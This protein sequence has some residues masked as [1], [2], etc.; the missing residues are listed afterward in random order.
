[1]HSFWD[2][3]LW[4]NSI[5]AWAT[6]VGMIIVSLLVLRMFKTIVLQRVKKLTQK[7]KGGFDDFLVSVVE[8]AVMPWLYCLAIY[9]SIQYLKIDARADKF[10]QV[11]IMVISTF[12]IV[13][14]ITIFLSYIVNRFIENSD[15]PESKR[16]QA[17]GILM[18]VK[19]VVYAI[20]LVFLIDN[21]GYDITTIVTGLG[22][23]GIAIAL[24]AQTILGDLFSYLVIF[25]DKPFEIGDYISMGTDS[26]TVEHIGIKTT[27]LKTLSGEQLICSNTDLTNSRIHNFKRMVERRVP[28]SFSVDYSTPPGKLEQIPGIVKEI[29]T[30]IDLTRFDRAHFTSL[31][32]DSLNFD[33]VYYVLTADYNQYMDIQQRIILTIMR[34]LADIQVEFSFPTRKVFIDGY[35]KQPLQVKVKGAE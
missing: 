30:S 25:F 14:I 28:F 21:L 17:R 26:G 35:E 13:R 23:G 4:G 2:Q 12:F 8:L 11:A 31:G 24:A 18:I 16:K 9:F 34:K 32:S 19:G 1:M 6:A 29:I 5:K 27:R 7:T 15:A 3:I 33:I 22:I 20:A 10:L